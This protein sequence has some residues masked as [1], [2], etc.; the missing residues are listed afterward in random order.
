MAET[1]TAIVT[2]PS[3]STVNLRV[4][5]NASSALVERVPIGTVVEILG[6]GSKWSKVKY[7]SKA[8]YMMTE[9][10]SSEEPV[11]EELTLEE[12]VARLEK[13]VTALEGVG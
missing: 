12:R 1:K 9:F 4:R 8:G 2:A 11:E 5:A 7:G 10:L 13:R 6:T 3:G